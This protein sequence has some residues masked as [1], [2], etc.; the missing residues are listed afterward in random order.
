MVQ[1]GHWILDIIFL[2]ANQNI[3]SYRLYLIMAVLKQILSQ[4]RCY[5]EE[6]LSEEEQKW[7]LAATE[8]LCCT[9]NLRLLYPMLIRLFQPKSETLQYLRELISG[10]GELLQLFS[11]VSDKH[12]KNGA[13]VMLEHFTE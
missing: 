8:T 6:T 11:N 13:E 4:L 1:L 10:N 3:I 7:F 2:L 12:M 9:T 5:S